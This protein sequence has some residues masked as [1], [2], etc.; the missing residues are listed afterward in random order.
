MRIL[1]IGS[2]GREH[3]I[4]KGLAADPATT[5]LHVAPGSPAFASLATVHGDYK[6]V[7]DPD[8]MVELARS[9]APDLVVIGPEIPLV[10]GVGDALREEGIAVFGPNAAAAQIEGSKAFAKEVMEAAGVAT[11]RAQTLPPGMTDDDIEHELDYF[12]PMYVVKDDGLAAG[13][14]VVVTSDRAEARQHIHLVHSAGNPVLLE[15]FLDGPEVSL[16]CLVDG[17]TVVPLL[18]AQD[19]KR[20]YD[21]DEGP[22]TGGMGAYT[23]LPW[24]PAEG[25][26]RIVREVCEP[27]AKEMVNRGTPYSGLLYAGLAWGEQG[28]SVIEF[29][30]RF[31]DPETQPLLALLKTPLAGVLN[32]VA[33]GTLDQLPPLEWE[34]AYAVTV[35]VAAANYPDDPRKGD[36]ITSPDLADAEKILH[37]GT[38]VKDAHVISNGGRVLN[39]IGK[40]ETLADAR[41]A[42]YAVLDNVELKDSFYRTDIGQAAEEGRIRIK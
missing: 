40:G 4:V 18:P 20:A 32:A 34:D 6:E 39:V 21:N 10:A 3:A 12:G 16:F 7:A 30:C 1:V 28:P 26:D 14:G 8:R 5:D 13:K 31:G 19:H 25:V 17:E 37:A 22:N 24:L 27:V 38:A 36:V 23:P 41:A 15:S 35:V 29:N 33:T 2:G 11:A 42:A 9:I